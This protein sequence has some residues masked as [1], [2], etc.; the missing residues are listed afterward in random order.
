LEFNI[1]LAI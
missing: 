1:Q